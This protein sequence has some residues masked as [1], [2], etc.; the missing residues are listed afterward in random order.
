MIDERLKQ[1]MY[2]HIDPTRW[3]PLENSRLM[4]CG[5]EVTRLEFPRGKDVM[6]VTMDESTREYPIHSQTQFVVWTLQLALVLA[7]RDLANSLA[8]EVVV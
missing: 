8:E 6:L 5:R 1:Y 4:F 2:R 3:Y 7:D